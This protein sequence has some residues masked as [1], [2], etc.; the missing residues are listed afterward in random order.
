MRVIESQVPVRG[1]ELY[2]RESGLGPAIVAL[3]GGPDFDSAY[4]LPELDALAATCRLVVYDQR[5]RGRSARGVRADD[6]SL[7]SELEDLD[8][9]RAHLGL[10][11]MTLLG[12]SWGA[13]LAMAYAMRRPE[14]VSHLVLMNP[15]PASGAEAAAMREDWQRAWPEDRAAMAVIAATPEFAA[16]D[17]ATEARYYRRH[18]APTVPAA[19]LEDLLAR[20]RAHFTPEGVRLAAAIEDRLLDDTWRRDGF[21]LVPG[22]AEQDIATLVLHGDRD[23]VPLACAERIARAVPRGRLEVVAGTGHFSYLERPVEVAGRI[24]AF[25]RA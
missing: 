12:H 16:G 15:A 21:D 19:L 25:V 3:H 10:D 9:L 22:L 2:V 18:Y 17:L 5:G 1:V 6:V 8:A 14:R 23:F 24:S 11:A 20:M 4:L 7:E 13:L